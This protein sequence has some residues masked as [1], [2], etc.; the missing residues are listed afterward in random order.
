MEFDIKDQTIQEINELI[1]EEFPKYTTQ[2]MNLANQNAG[3]TRPKQVGQM[4]ELFPE[5]LKTHRDISRQ[6]WEQFYMKNHQEQ[7]REAV[8]K[9][10]LQIY[11]LREAI[12]KIDKLM[13]RKW[14]KDLLI[15]KTYDG[16]YVQKAILIELGKRKG[17]SIRLATPEEEAKGIDGFVGDI[18]YSVKPVTYEAMDRLPENIAYKMIYYSKSG[19]KIHIKVEE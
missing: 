6:G 12:L 5:Y 10:E 19:K 2:L 7:V 4:S 18:P 9:I 14:V 16:M 13:I 8:N 3:A 17:L 15:N 11:N 1:P